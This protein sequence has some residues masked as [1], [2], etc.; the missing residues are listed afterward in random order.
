M[1]DINN[2]D[3][4][5]VVL[6][7]EELETFSRLI[8]EK[9]GNS[10]HHYKQ[11]VV[12]RR[13][14]RRMYLRGV[15]SVRDYLDM[16]AE[17]DSE[18]GLLACDLMIGVTSFFRDMPAWKALRTAVIIKLATE[19]EESPVRVWTP[20]C[21]TGEEAYSIAMMLR[22]EFELAG[23][24]RKIQVFA[25]DV[26]VR[27]LAKAREGTYPASV[28]ADIPPDYMRRFFSNS[29]DGLSVIIGKEIRDSVIFARQDLLV[30]PPF[31]RL[32]LVICRNFLIYLEPHAQERC[33]ALFHYALK[34]GAHLFLG[35]A[36]YAGKS[37]KLFTTLGLK[38]CRIYRKIEC[39][40]SLR[41][42][43]PVPFAAER[44]RALPARVA[45]PGNC[46]ESV[47]GFVQEALL[48]KFAPAAVAIDRNYDILYHNGPTSRYLRQ[49]RGVPSQNL[50]E[51]L[52]EK[53]RSRVRGAL[54][55][56]AG[57]AEPVS[58]RADIHGDGGRKRQVT[59]RMSQ[60]R[61]DVFLVVFREKGELP[62]SG[63]TVAPDADCADETAVRQL[64]IELSAAHSDLQ[65]HM[66]QLNSLNEELQASNEEFQAANEELETS[67]E[68][69]HTLNEEL[70]TVNSQLQCKFEE[71]EETNNDLNNFQ[72]STNIPTLFLDDQFRVKRFTPAMS[73]LLKLI[74]SDVG[75]PIVDMSQERLGPDLLTDA[76][77]VLD[78]PAPVQKQMLINDVWYLRAVLPYRTSNSSIEGVVITYTDVTRLKRAKE[79]L[80]ESEQRVRLKLDSILTPEGDI[81]NLD[82]ADI[83]EVPAVQSLMD[84]FY[85]LARIPMSIIDLEGNVLVGKGWQDICLKFH[86]VH[87]ESC[88]HCVDSDLKLSG[89][90]PAGEFKL[91]KCK[92]SMWDM[93]TPIMVG[94]KH[95]GN[96]FMGQFFF[97]DE[98]LDYETFRSQARH[99][100][101]DEG[102]YIAALEGVPRLSRKTVEE[103]MAYLMKFA[104]LISKLS[105]SNIKLA[106]SLT[107]RDTLMD[108]LVQ[109]KEEW[110]RTF[111]AVPDLIVILD[112][113]HRVVRANRAMAERL[114]VTPEQ[115]VGK[116]CYEVVHGLG[117]PPDFCPHVRTLAD[118]REAEA[119][120][121]ESRL[122]G[123]FLVSTTPLT[124]DEGRRIGTV[125]VAR[126]ITE[127]KRAEEALRESERRLNRAQE[128]AHLGSWE[129]N[130]VSNRLTWSDEVYR[131]FGLRPQEFS[132]TYEAFLEAVHPDDRAAV[133]AAYSDSLREERDTYEIEHRVV[134]KSSGEVRIVHEKCEHFR[135]TSGRIIRSVGMVHDISERKRAEEAL[136]RAHD[137]LEIKVEE[138]TAELREKDQML[139]MQSRQAA[140]GEMI[141]NIAHQWRQPLNALSL[142]VQTLPMM[143][144]MGELSLEYL[145]SIEE[146]SMGIIKHMSQTIDDFRNYF[147]PDKE[148]LPFSVREAVS[149]TLS[150]IEDS[151][152]HRPIAVEVIAVDDPV[153]IGYSNEYCQVLLNI[154]LNAR[155]AFP[156]EIVDDAKVVITMGLESDRAVVTIADNAG[157]IAEDVMD[158]IFDP[159]F[160]TKGP[161]QGTGVGL[162]MSKAIIEKNMGGR[163]SARNTEGGAEF[164]IEV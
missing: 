110:E 129:L 102:E 62:E 83:I 9:T 161:D 123:D 40:P 30:D 81:G 140:M 104:D 42:A 75:R 28:A 36:E 89:G 82:L 118:G 133:D 156:E 16:V 97:D 20:A 106:R 115:C 45:S 46:R 21:A 84:N 10:C 14:T 155:D 4:A 152:K 79:A 57:D 107:E 142:I 56:S 26:D 99:Y 66:E 71:Q 119:E 23:R 150:L 144:E 121:H 103:G 27:S 154:L 93:A 32:D 53:L 98:E 49:P 88:R 63:V 160:T 13:I 143:R 148:K 101:F 18:A 58:I 64:E 85:E 6:T 73:R 25:T 159:Y 47:V 141:G 96:L 65:S 55:R 43:T 3:S 11:G 108:S 117:C 151:F 127:R 22:Q 132:A 157:G 5:P 134:R 163:L 131:I 8:H 139:L 15:P 31:S 112:E 59:I 54:Y 37:S 94:G 51:L 100:G 153:I 29:E 92:N 12:A 60:L 124:D 80:R 44:C 158:K 128:I 116:I 78:N 90:I 114:G 130:L 17:S 122:G 135:D 1:K 70:V 2:E 111:H 86:R 149:R 138:R 125:H 137:E 68:E 87:P 50:L 74:S 19:N 105:Y 39:E 162:F 113:Q 35:N 164:R 38:K 126:D 61:G 146:R 77:S 95:L 33:M 91:Y 147:R 76:R 69:L 48:E 24:Q 67:R 109:A 72:A 145:E 136:Q 34:D 52:P 120:V 41:P 7:Q